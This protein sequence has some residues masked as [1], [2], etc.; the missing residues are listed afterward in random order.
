MLTSGLHSVP[1]I[2]LLLLLTALLTYYRCGGAPCRA[3]LCYPQA[4]SMALHSVTTSS[5]TAARVW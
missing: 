1:A 3:P 4:D 2:A 5:S